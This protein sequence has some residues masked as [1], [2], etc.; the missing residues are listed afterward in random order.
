MKLQCHNSKL[1]HLLRGLRLRG[2]CVRGLSLATS[3]PDGIV[4]TYR[5]KLDSP[6]EGRWAPWSSASRK[7]SGI[8]ALTSG[9][10]R[11]PFRSG[12]GSRSTGGGTIRGC[13]RCM[14]NHGCAFLCEL[15]AERREAVEHALH[16]FSLDHRRI[17]WPGGELEAHQQ[18][19]VDDVGDPLHLEGRQDL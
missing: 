15:N 18:R 19:I 1:K 17:A 6:G 12:T 11:N 4:P 7:Q 16:G 5:S 10:C 2:L 3:R 13:R 9:C 8:C 14:Q